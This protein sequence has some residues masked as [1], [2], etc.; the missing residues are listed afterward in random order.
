MQYRLLALILA[1]RIRV[2]RLDGR[3]FRRGQFIGDPVAGRRGSIDQFS[4]TGV[5]GGF[6][7]AHRSLDVGGH[8]V[9]RAVDRGNDIADTG[10]V[11]Y[12]LSAAEEGIARLQ[13]TD[14]LAFEDDVRVGAVVFDVEQ[15]AAHE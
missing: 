8:V 7:H 5:T 4:N 9:H 6:E 3:G 15:A 12:I 2:L 13:R 11:K 1:E 14:V 10:E